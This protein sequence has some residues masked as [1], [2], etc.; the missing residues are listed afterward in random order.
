[1]KSTHEMNVV[2]RYLHSK[3]GFKLIVELGCHTLNPHRSKG[4]GT[5]NLAIETSKQKRRTFFIYIFHT[6]FNRHD[7]PTD[8]PKST[9]LLLRCSTKPKRK[10]TDRN[11]VLSDC[12]YM[13]VPC[14]RNDVGNKKMRR[15]S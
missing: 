12:C 5:H 14:I 15:G 2:L 9:I 8:F 4:S 11:C 10:E 1:M 3:I 7:R 13:T 6:R